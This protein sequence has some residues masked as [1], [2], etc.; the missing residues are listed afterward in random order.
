MKN[1]DTKIPPNNLEAE[2]AVLGSIFLENKEL[3]NVINILSENDFYNTSH[4]KIFKTILALNNDGKSIDYVTVCNS[5]RDERILD[6]C[7]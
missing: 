2:Q 3:S 6:S 4:Q 1:N 5:L 7:G